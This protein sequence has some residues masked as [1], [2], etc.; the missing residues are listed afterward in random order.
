[1]LLEQR[2]DHPVVFASTEYYEKMLSNFESALV[3]HEVIILGDFNTNYVMDET[4]A[5]N[6]AHHIELLLN[7]SQLT[8]KS[9]RVTKKTSTT[10]DLICTSMPEYHS[11][12]GVAECSLSDQDMI[13][14]VL[15]INTT[16]RSKPR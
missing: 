12:S 1:M 4:L 7:C 10:V 6:A 5:D 15:K 16:K 9:T 2:V 14:T 3:D 8:D 11:S 13:Y